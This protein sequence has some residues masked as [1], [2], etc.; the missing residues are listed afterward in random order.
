MIEEFLPGLDLVC[1]EGGIL[2]D[3]EL[4]ISLH[5]YTYLLLSPT[6]YSNHHRSSLGHM[7]HL[8]LQLLTNG[9]TL[10]LGLPAIPYSFL[11]VLGVKDKLG[12]RWEVSLRESLQVPVEIGMAG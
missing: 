8:F 12:K 3:A 2:G 9:G 1:V 5:Y 10:H 6:L 11:V 4:W 7:L